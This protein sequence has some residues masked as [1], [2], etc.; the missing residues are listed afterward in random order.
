VIFIFLQLVFMVDYV[1]RFSYIES[2]LHCWDD[3]YFILMDDV[4]D[5][6]LDSFCEYFIANFYINVHNRNR[7][8]ILFLC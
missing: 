1:D 8:E 7:S 4:F 5:E 3:A 2:F 6:I